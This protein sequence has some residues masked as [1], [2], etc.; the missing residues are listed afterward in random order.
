MSTWQ[1][2]CTIYYES[3]KLELD[4]KYRVPQGSILGPL[5]F[6][7]YINDLANTIKKNKN[8]ETEIILYADDTNI[9]IACDSLITVKS[10][11]MKFLTN[12]VA[13]CYVICCM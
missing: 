9:F 5:L 11:P 2:G 13:S 12:L 8:Y 10:S 4:I 1:L 3:D 7:L 6:L